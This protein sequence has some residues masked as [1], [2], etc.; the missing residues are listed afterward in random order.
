MTKYKK[1]PVSCYNCRKSKTKCDRNYPCSKCYLKDI[2]CSYPDKFRSLRLDKLIKSKSSGETPRTENSSVLSYDSNAIQQITPPE[3]F[4]VQEFSVFS[5][6]SSDSQS[7]H[8]DC[9]TRIDIPGIKKSIQ[10]SHQS[11]LMF[12]D[13]SFE[14]SGSLVSV[15][16]YPEGMDN[17]LEFP[18]FVQD[19][20]KNIILIKTLLDEY[21]RVADLPTISF[22]I[23]FEEMSRTI[24]D[25]EKN[26]TW[27]LYKDHL[28]LAISILLRIL[29]I[30]PLEHPLLTNCVFLK[31]REVQIDLF[32]RFFFLRNLLI[33]DSSMSVEAMLIL[34]EE[35]LYEDEYDLCS[36]T[37]LELLNCPFYQELCTYVAQYDCL[38]IQNMSPKAKLDTVIKDKKILRWSD[39]FCKFCK[40]GSLLSIKLF[41]EPFENRFPILKDA[42]LKTELK[43][44]LAESAMKGLQYP[45]VW[46]RT[47]DHDK[48]LSQAVEVEIEVIYD[49]NYHKLKIK[50]LLAGANL[51]ESSIATIAD[52][53]FPIVDEEYGQID[54]DDYVPLELTSSSPQLQH[55]KKLAD[56]LFVI[57]HCQMTRVC[58]SLPSVA[59]C[60]NPLKLCLSSLK[61]GLNCILDLIFIFLQIKRV[62]CGELSEFDYDQF[63]RAIP[64]I[65]LYVFKFVQGFFH[66]LHL[67]SQILSSQRYQIN[68]LAAMFQQ[69]KSKI[70]TS[71]NVGPNK[72]ILR[73]LDAIEHLCTD[74]NASN[75]DLKTT[76]SGISPA[77][78]SCYNEKLPGEH[79]LGRSSTMEFNFSKLDTKYC[80]FTESLKKGL[81]TWK[82]NR[83][84][85]GYRIKTEPLTGTTQLVALPGTEFDGTLDSF[86]ELFCSEH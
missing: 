30:I 69:L 80:P 73:Y 63:R 43:L 59:L 4:S 54:V 42:S 49:I 22:P 25:A 75:D 48:L 44:N 50:N 64:V 61:S 84:S 45:F 18:Q 78:R 53:D 38:T 34:V 58:L 41:H 55:L 20:E 37:I 81:N 5:T 39:L 19:K 70:A 21:F 26:N 74:I 1:L 15:A 24:D 83:R 16:Q 8:T 56:N 2:K 46:M 85:L 86:Y 13:T 36:S 33:L 77:A 28:F 12:L 10:F 9:E 7:H 3:E 52:D 82:M 51:S 31:D 67:E 40:Y 57:A 17:P 72:S 65:N 11:D 62:L 23:R 47:S 32:K 60:H 35:C 27:H 6:V 66:I 29:N 71:A 14:V 68:I 79:I 76:V